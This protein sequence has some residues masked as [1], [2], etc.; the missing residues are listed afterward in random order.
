MSLRNLRLRLLEH[1]RRRVAQR[2]LRAL[3]FL[4]QGSTRYSISHWAFC[5]ARCLLNRLRELGRG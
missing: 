1:R 4:L 5:R 2:Q 3:G